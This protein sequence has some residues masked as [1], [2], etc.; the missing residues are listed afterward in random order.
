MSTVRE[1]KV[2]NSTLSGFSFFLVKIDFNSVCRF[3]Y[4]SM[5]LLKFD[6]L[7]LFHFG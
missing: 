2:I 1:H 4:L 6:I 3:I 7:L 5:I